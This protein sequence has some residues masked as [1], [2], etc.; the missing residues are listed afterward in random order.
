M[1]KKSR[2]SKGPSSAVCAAVSS[3]PTVVASSAPKRKAQKPIPAAPGVPP[4][5]E[6]HGAPRSMN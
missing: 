4:W 6:L 3:E 5:R 2:P 1:A